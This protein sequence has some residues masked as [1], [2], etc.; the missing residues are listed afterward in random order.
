MFGPEIEN[1]LNEIY[2][3]GSSSWLPPM[4]GIGNPKNRGPIITDARN[5][6]RK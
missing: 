4:I 1:Y 6:P 2:L 3:H 5:S